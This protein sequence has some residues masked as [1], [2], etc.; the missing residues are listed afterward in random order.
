ME[1]DPERTERAKN[2]ARMALMAARRYERDA[3]NERAKAETL[4]RTWGFSPAEL[5]A[6]LDKPT[7]P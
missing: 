5:E 1:L 6:E 3:L 4:G 2:R 7:Q